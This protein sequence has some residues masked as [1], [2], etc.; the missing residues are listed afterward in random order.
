MINFFFPG[1]SNAQFHSCQLG[2]RQTLL[3]RNSVSL[4]IERKGRW[5][6]RGHQS[7][8]FMLQLT[9]HDYWSDNSATN[10]TTTDIFRMI[11]LL[12]FLAQRGIVRCMDTNWL[13]QQNPVQRWDKVRRGTR[14]MLLHPRGKLNQCFL[15]K[16]LGKWWIILIQTHPFCNLTRILT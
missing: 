1:R 12:W 9:S 14:R 11:K 5:R 2:T 7:D 3:P 10:H 15:V 4:N 6:E 13:L 8:E 16:I